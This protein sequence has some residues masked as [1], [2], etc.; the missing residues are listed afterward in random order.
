MK[1]IEIVYDVVCPFCLLGLTRIERRIEATGRTISLE[2][3]PFFLDRRIPAGGVSFEA[4][5]GAKYGARSKPM[6]RQLETI[7]R[8]EGVNFD[9]AHLK[10]APPSLS[11]HVLIDLAKRFGK[12][13]EAARAVMTAYFL[14]HR[15]IQDRDTLLEIG[16]AIG[17]ERA[18]VARALDDEETAARIDRDAAAVAAMGV[19]SVP[20]YFVD[21]RFV[22]GSE[23]LLPLL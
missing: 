9:F 7:A 6:M 3:R 23:Q 4:Y 15:E 13:T 5:H 17:L 20:S 19:S 10:T 18:A 11:A 14:E 22:G 1:Q 16:E 21:G 2:W 8:A 12:A